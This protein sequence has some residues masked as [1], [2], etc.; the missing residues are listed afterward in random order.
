MQAGLAGVHGN[1]SSFGSANGISVV[2]LADFGKPGVGG[3]DGSSGATG[4]SSSGGSASINNDEDE[5][6]DDD[7][8]VLL[9]GGEDA[10]RSP[11]N[12]DKSDMYGKTLKTAVARVQNSGSVSGSITARAQQLKRP[13]NKNSYTPQ[14]YDV[15]LITSGN[16]VSLFAS[17][18]R[19][20]K[21]ATRVALDNVNNDGHISGQIRQISGNNS[22]YNSPHMMSGSEATGSGNGI[23]L[24]SDTFNAQIPRVE[25]RLGK[26]KIAP[27]VAVQPG[28]SVNATPN[29]ATADPANGADNSVTTNTATTGTTAN[30]ATNT[31]GSLA[32]L[33]RDH[34][35]A[36]ATF[37]TPYADAY[38]SYTSAWRNTGDNPLKNSSYL[39]ENAQAE[40]A[41]NQYLADTVAHNP[42][43]AVPAATLAA[44]QDTRRELLDNHARPL[45]QGETYTAISGS[46]ARNDALKT[47]DSKAHDNQ[48]GIGI[49]HGITSD[50]TLGITASVGREKT[51]GS[52]DSRLKGNSHYIGAHAVKTLGDLSLTGGLAYSQTRLKGTR[53]IN[54][55]YDAQ[56]HAA[57]NKPSVTSAYAESKYTLHVNDRLAWEPKAILAYNHLKTGN[58]SESGSGGLTIASRGINTVD[59]G[60][61]QDL[62]YSTKAGSGELRGKLSLDFI[63]TS[64][65][66]DLQA[67]FNGSD[68]GFTLRTDKNP[69]TVRAGLTGEYQ[70]AKGVIIRAGVSDNLRKGKNDLQGT[71]S[72]GVKF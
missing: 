41:V 9:E 55:G 16:G 14:F 46:L 27:R 28:Q 60:I 49:S 42:Y 71:L 47:S 3:V 64:G 69:N 58:V 7:L 40:K 25:T 23:S 5:I 38:N 37:E 8:L 52:H 72:V 4:K 24:Y 12:T 43:G 61:G 35:A 21:N 36:S 32:R 30:T 56:S 20:A 33:N 44:H 50:L 22:G 70:T 13:L 53:H 18:G 17:T 34:D 67:R 6:E 10:E 1:V 31:V 68:S 26:I 39:P 2:A 19:F 57:R 51:N 63:H 15:S 11:K 62:T 54:N 48:L 65:E 66:K 59:I 29:S 45:R